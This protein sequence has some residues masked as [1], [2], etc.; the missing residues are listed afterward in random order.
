M[1][2][3]QPLHVS[4]AH[5]IRKVSG[6]LLPFLFLLYIVAYI[7]RINVGFAALQMQ[8]QLGLNDT[9][10]G[11]GA[12][13]FFA[14]YFLFQVPSNWALERIGA[15]RWIAFLLIAWGIIS[16]SMLFI[17][18]ER[19]FYVLRF[20]LGVTEAGF[21]PGM[22]F[23]LRNWFPA[24]A[25]ARAVAIFMTASPMAGVIGGPISGALLNV[26]AGG[27]SGWQWMFLLE[28]I[29]AVLLSGI[30]YFFL[31]DKPSDAHWLSPP[32]SDWLLA[33]LEDE[34]QHAISKN[35]APFSVLWMPAVWLLSVMYFGMNIAIYGIGFWLPKIIRSQ[36]GMSTFH[37]GLLTAVPYIFSAIAMVVVGLHS[38]RTGERRLHVALCAFAGVGGL[39][40]AA[41][42]GSFPLMFL[43]ISIAL[44]A[45]NSMYGPY[46]AMPTAFLPR[47]LAAIGIAVINSL[48]NLGGFFGPYFIG[49]LKTSSGTFQNPLLLVAGFLMLAGLVTLTLS[50]FTRKPTPTAVPVSSS[51]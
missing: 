45:A 23:Y 29:P 40:F 35:T 50:F 7:D 5:V 20:L 13:M 6:R 32:E 42:S 39:V 9:I 10:Y 27:L 24:G 12:G 14:G 37:I 38:D 3:T 33:T 21:F 47:A 36:S 16:S 31:T 17:R 15:R 4:P 26:H 49:L 43:G 44:L 28:G 18:G 41:F 46:W 30:V 25:R 2:T 34:Q 51:R 22:I 48:G 19:S 8:G 1:S 11:L